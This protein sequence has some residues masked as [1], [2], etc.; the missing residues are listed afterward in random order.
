MEIQ[1]HI[2]WLKHDRIFHNRTNYLKDPS[3]YKTIGA[4]ESFLAIIDPQEHRMQRQKISSLFSTKAVE[5]MT[6]QILAIAQTAA[7]CV[8]KFG[9]NEQPIDMHRLCRSFSVSWFYILITRIHPS[10]LILL[11]TYDADSG[12]SQ[13]F[14]L[15]YYSP[16][17]RI[18]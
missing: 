18:Y 17:L 11:I 8:M 3:F 2:Q 13:T 5:T 14:Y 1:L 6:P 9:E 7:K 15:K 16:N 4:T 10:F 12:Y